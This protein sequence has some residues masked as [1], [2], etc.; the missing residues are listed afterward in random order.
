MCEWI[1]I[2]VNVIANR[3]P[4]TGDTIAILDSDADNQFENKDDTKFIDIGYVIRSNQ[5]CDLGENNQEN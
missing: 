5:H 3:I 2:P 4:N 1:A